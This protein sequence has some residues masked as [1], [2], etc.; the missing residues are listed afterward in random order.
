MSRTNML[1]DLDLLTD[2]PLT[3]VVDDMQSL[4]DELKKSL[5]EVDQLKV[6]KMRLEV[7]NRDLQSQLDEVGRKEEKEQKNMKRFAKEV[8]SLRKQVKEWKLK[9]ARLKEQSREDAVRQ[10]QTFTEIKKQLFKQLQM[11]REKSKQLEN[12][13]SA[14]KKQIAN[15]PA[16]S[17]SKKTAITLRNFGFFGKSDVDEKASEEKSKN[18]IAACNTESYASPK[19][20]PSGQSLP[21]SPAPEKSASVVLESSEKSTSGSTPEGDEKC[22]REL[23]TK[24]QECQNLRDEVKRLEDRLAHISTSNDQLIIEID[25]VKSS[26]DVAEA[27]LYSTQSDFQELKN[28]SKL[29]LDDIRSLKSQISSTSSQTRLKELDLNNKLEMAETAKRDAL[30]KKENEIENLKL[31]HQQEIANLKD[32]HEKSYRAQVQTT[33]KL[34]NELQILQNSA[35]QQGLELEKMSSAVENY[36]EKLSDANEKGNIVEQRKKRL[37]KEKKALVKE[38]KRLKD[39]VTEFKSVKESREQLENKIKQLQEDEI[40]L[41]IEIKSIEDDRVKYKSLYNKVVQEREAAVDFHETTMK[42]LKTKLKSVLDVGQGILMTLDNMKLEK[43]RSSTPGMKDVQRLQWAN[44]EIQKSIIPTIRK[45]MSSEQ[46]HDST[47]MFTKSVLSN[48]L[49]KLCQ[50]FLHSN[51]ILLKVA[52]A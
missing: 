45:H 26:K 37:E 15:P 9:E 4:R 13:F 16:L 34:S 10:K 32:S 25:G 47:V 6:E 52:A 49:L 51:I 19:V 7:E 42:E 3:K 21:T 2:E 1:M 41:T 14:L 31:E 18:A 29:Y 36:K 35:V 24:T 50:T 46:E 30:L 20:S 39:I 17:T 33:E 44:I 11:E 23:E 27:K 12:K 40:K 5:Q 43:L 38:L 28:K 48:V 22:R 8:L